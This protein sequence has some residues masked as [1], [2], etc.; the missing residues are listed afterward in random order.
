VNQLLFQLAF[1]SHSAHTPPPPPPPPHGEWDT[2]ARTFSFS[3]SPF[4]FLSCHERPYSPRL[5][6]FFGRW[7]SVFVPAV[8]FF[9]SFPP[10]GLFQRRKEPFINGL[11]PS[12]LTNSPTVFAFIRTRILLP[13]FRQLRAAYFSTPG[14]SKKTGH[15]YTP[16]FF[17]RATLSLW[18]R[19]RS[20]YSFES[21]NRLPC[22]A[23]TLFFNF[24]EGWIFTL[25]P[26]LLS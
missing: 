4:F 6:V 23:F 9:A 21:I 26:F 22:V 8:L 11:L 7:Q 3:C 1:L 15:F 20:I 17:L 18:F 2:I 13:Y 25:L 16:L 5:F 24:Y 14:S 10:P 19:P 12:S